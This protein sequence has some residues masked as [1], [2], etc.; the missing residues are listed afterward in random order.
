MYIM[1]CWTPYTIYSTAKEI[2]MHTANNMTGQA[3]QWQSV[4]GWK[5]TGSSGECRCMKW[6]LTLSNKD[7]KKQA[8][9]LHCKQQGISKKSLARILTR[10]DRNISWSRRHVESHR[11]SV[12]HCPPSC[13]LRHQLLFRRWYCTTRRRCPTRPLAA[14]TMDMEVRMC[15]PSQQ[16]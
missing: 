8:G 9:M 12:W 1:W 6:P 7:G 5:E 14:V 10:I 15:D 3:E 4:H 13:R 16:R 2:A 11:Y